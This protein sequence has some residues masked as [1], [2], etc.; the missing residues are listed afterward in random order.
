M[1]KHKSYTFELLKKFQKE[2]ENQ[3]TKMIKIL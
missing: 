2:V 3:L 1:I